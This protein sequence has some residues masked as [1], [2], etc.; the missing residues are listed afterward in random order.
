MVGH[1]PRDM[2]ICRRCKYDAPS[3]G[4]GRTDVVQDLF[5]VGQG[6]NVRCRI[7]RKGSLER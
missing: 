3:L 6:G 7:L 2:Q 1:V 4:A 5:T